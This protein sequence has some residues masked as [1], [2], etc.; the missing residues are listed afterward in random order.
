[1]TPKTNLVLEDIRSK[2]EA[3]NPS[4]I[5]DVLFKYLD[6]IIQALVVQYG[7]EENAAAVYATDIIDALAEEGEIPPVPVGGVPPEQAVEWVGVMTTLGIHAF[8]CEMAAEEFGA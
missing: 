6:D 8:I 1:M 5:D 2:M 7:L 3:A 4:D